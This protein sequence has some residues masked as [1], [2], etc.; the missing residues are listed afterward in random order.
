MSK[1]EPKSNAGSKESKESPSGSFLTANATLVSWLIFL[2]FGSAVLTSYYAH[3]HYLPELKWEESF[4]YLAAVTV[5]GGGIVAVYALL[6]YLPGWIW[7]EFLIFDSELQGSLCYLGLDGN[8]PEPCFWSIVKK[9]VL[10]FAFLMVVIHL[11]M[12]ADSV[13]L[14]AVATVVGLTG[15]AWYSRCEFLSHKSLKTHA[16]R[17]SLLMKYTVTSVVAA[18]AGIVSLFI[19]RQI[20]DPQK[21]SGKLLLTCTVAVIVSNLLVAVQFRNKPTRAVLTGIIA[22]ITLLI[23]GETFSESHQSQ[24]EG[25]MRRFGVGDEAFKIKLSVTDEGRKL[26]ADNKL[27]ADGALVLRSRLGE[28]YLVEGDNEQRVA[29]PKRMVNFWSSVHDIRKDPPKT[30]ERS[31][32]QV[33][34]AV[35]DCVFLGPVAVWLLY[36]VVGVI[37]SRL[38]SRRAAHLWRAFRARRT[39]IVIGRSEE[40]CRIGLGDA[41]AVTEIQDFF[42]R[43]RLSRPELVTADRLTQE[44]LNFNLILLGGPDTNEIS[45]CLSAGIGATMRF[46]I[47]NALGCTVLDLLEQRIFHPS[48]VDQTRDVF[49]DYVLIYRMNNPSN[50]KAQ[51]LLIAGSPGHGARVGIRHLLSESF[52]EKDMSEKQGPFELLLKSEVHYGVPQPPASQ[53]VLRPL[54]AW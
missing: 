16:T 44:D 32:Y 5:L 12:F 1:S 20:I 39:R 47:C 28:E 3:I 19:L 37:H 14:M 30:Y 54:R 33:A 45:K 18:L 4:S 29:I 40:S 7:S 23:C 43:L 35:A 24:S 36:G 41:V 52:C 21:H 48:W 50:R 38:R 2:G 9:V 34:A 15:L 46:G 22:A 26:L 27:S 31:D 53:V 13:P 49:H 6:L 25:I 42:A 17:R 8:K 51:I 11:A 10:P